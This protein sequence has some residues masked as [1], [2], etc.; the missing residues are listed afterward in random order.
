MPLL[1]AAEPPLLP[2]LL[3]LGCGRTKHTPNAIF[4]P[5]S[6]ATAT[7]ASFRAR[8]PPATGCDVIDVSSCASGGD[9]GKVGGES[10][11]IKSEET[12]GVGLMGEACVIES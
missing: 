8:A 5:E 7:G 10:G 3:G 12:L 9:I 6:V 4:L 1:T 11:L 2:P